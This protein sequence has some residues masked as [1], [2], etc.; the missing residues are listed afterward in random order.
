MEGHW[1]STC[2][3]PKHLVDLYQAFIKKKGKG[4]GTNFA[5]H[6]DPED[7]MNYVDF[8]KWNGYDL[9]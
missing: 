2:C 4:I 3:T 5:N 1:L 8:S 9:S 7:P 6:N